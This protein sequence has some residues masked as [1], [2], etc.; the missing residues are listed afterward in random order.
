MCA[1]LPQREL[2][3]MPTGFDAGEAV[4][5]VL[6]YV[7]AHQMLHRSAKVGPGQRVLIHG[8]IAIDC[9]HQDL[10]NEIHHLAGDGV[11]NSPGLPTNWSG[12]S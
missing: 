5:F 6:N 8:A 12:I 2:V 11:A 1:C 9:P 4:S 7:T 3:P 10:V